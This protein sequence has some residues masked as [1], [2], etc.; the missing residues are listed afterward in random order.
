MASTCTRS[1]QS[2][3][4]VIRTMLANV[5]ITYFA[6]INKKKVKEIGNAKKCLIS[7]VFV[8]CNFFI[9]NPETPCTPERF[10]SSTTLKNLAEINN[11]QQKL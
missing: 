8:L 11:K 1:D 9:V 5:N 3:F 6:D 7:R 10:F 4:I 2:N